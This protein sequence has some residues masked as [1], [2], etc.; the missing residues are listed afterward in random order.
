MTHAIAENYVYPSIKNKVKR[1]NVVFVNT[2]DCCAWKQLSLP[3]QYK[4]K[5]D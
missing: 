3:E 2:L 5:L 4:K 1:C